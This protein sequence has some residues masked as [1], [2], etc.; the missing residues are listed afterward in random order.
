M[1]ERQIGY[2]KSSLVLSARLPVVKWRSRPVAK[3]AYYYQLPFCNTTFYFHA[4]WRLRTECRKSITCHYPDQGSAPEWSSH[5][6]NLLQPIRNT[7]QI[8]MVM[9]YQYWISALVPRTSFCVETSG[10]ITSMTAVFLG[11]VL[12][13]FRNCNQWINSVEGSALGSI[14]Y[15][16]RDK[17]FLFFHSFIFNFNRTDMSSSEAITRGPVGFVTPRQGG[18]GIL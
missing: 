15:W 3:S 1:A 6:G 11:Q 2:R 13:V 7:N 8:W 14:T 5:V 18:E 10:G 17:K 4:K 9:R 16:H 12:L